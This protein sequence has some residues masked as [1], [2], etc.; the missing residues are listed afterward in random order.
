M[1]VTPKLAQLQAVTN[2]LRVAA[3]KA[4]DVAAE[5][6]G[7]LKTLL[8]GLA[9]LESGFK[10]GAGSTF[11]QVQLSIEQNLVK[12]TDA[13]LEVAEGVR[14]SGADFDVQD[15]EAQSLVSKTMDDTSIVDR[16]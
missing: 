14:T 5:I 8:A 1:G 16:L 11:Q 2:D 3:G 4:D 13:L 9:P 12:I 15:S 10:G 7:N 6:T